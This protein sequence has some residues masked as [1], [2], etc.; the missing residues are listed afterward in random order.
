LPTEDFAEKKIDCGKEKKNN[1][2]VKTGENM[3]KT[4]TDE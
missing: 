4:L 2:A 3:A 1:A